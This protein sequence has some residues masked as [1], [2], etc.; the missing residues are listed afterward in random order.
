M[1]PQI[2]PQICEGI[3]VSVFKNRPNA[4]SVDSVIQSALK[5][6]DA[7][8]LSACKANDKP[9]VQAMVNSIF[10]A[11]PVGLLALDSSIVIPSNCD[12]IENSGPLDTT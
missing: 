8:N 1:Y 9:C 5:T 11:D 10:N 6:L 2:V 12:S 4:I 3:F 7:L